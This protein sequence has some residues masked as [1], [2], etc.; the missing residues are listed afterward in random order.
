MSSVPDGRA[1]NHPLSAITFRP[2]IGAPLPGARVRMPSIFSPASSRGTYLPWRELRQ[3]SFLLRRRRRVDAVVNGFAELVRKLTV[4][5]AGI[6][7]HARRD[8]RRQQRRDDAVLVGRPDAAIQA[9]KGSTRALFPAKAQRA[10]EQAFDEP[11]ETDRHLV[12]LAAELRR[13]AIDHLAADDRL[14]DRRVPCSTAADAGRGRKWRPK[15]SDWAAASPR[16]G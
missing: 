11:L 3:H 16:S 6:A 9:D 5:F 12:E 10:V 7:A 2:P 1:A 14:A 13:D 8:L 15:G 4:D